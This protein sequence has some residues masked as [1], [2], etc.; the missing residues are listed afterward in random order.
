MEAG[1]GEEVR[2]LF[3]GCAVATSVCCALA[4]ET[5][6]LKDDFETADAVAKWTL[7]K[8]VSLVDGAGVDG[9][10]GL[11]WEQNEFREMQMVT[12]TVVTVDG[13]AVRPMP[14]AVPERFV[15][16]VSV[17][18]GRVYSISAKVRGA[19]TNNCLYLFFAWYDKDGRFIGRA[20]G[21]PTIYRQ[22]GCKGWEVVRTK[23]QRLP[24]DAASAKLFVELYRTTL[25]RMAF[26]DFTV[27]C[28]EARH[29][30]RVF[31][32]AYRN[33]QESGPV[34]FVAPY[35]ASPERFPRAR[36][37][38]EFSFVGADGDFTLKTDTVTD[39]RFEVTVDCARLK[40]GMSSVTARLF[41]DGKEL[42]S[43]AMDFTRAKVSRKV[44]FDA[45]QRLIVDGKPFLPLGVFVHPR[46]KEVAYL[47][48]LRNS[49]FN[50]VI[51]CTPEK[52]IM[53]K[54]HAAGLMTLPKMTWNLKYAAGMAR[55]LRDHPSLLAW[56]VIDEVAPDRADEKR[57]LQ[58][59]VAENDPDHPTF[60]VLDR[61]R[62]A[63]AM[64]GAFDIVSCDPYPVGR[65]RGELSKASEF[66]TLCRRKTYGLCPLWQ[67]PQ[68]FAWDWCHKYGHP[69]EDRYPTYE[70]LRSM[71]WQAIAAGANGLL[72]Y[73][74]HHI[75]KCSPAERLEENW[76]N[77]VKVADEIKSHGDVIL[78][79]GTTATSS[80]PS[81]VVRAFEKDGAVWLLAA[82][83]ERVEST[84]VVDVPG[85]RR[86]KVTLPALGVQLKK[87]GNR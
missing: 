61:P 30:E 40:E 70:E 38:G 41:F 27:T 22:V 17:E 29:L 66:P 51:E 52:A 12:Q 13:N 15:R 65:N 78:S 4:V 68:S 37:S 43:A 28:D 20:E 2:K 73:S 45:A 57:E 3:V 79:E 35:V 58:K 36:L 64:M 75:F 50:C 87:I 25:G 67:V 84:A 42:A 71:A 39:D 63:D 80:S 53:D 82:N 34:R 77:L 56:Y 46:D 32:S 7:C 31:S 11:V 72:W 86:G 8:G 26:D 19:I 62:N 81:V 76:G 6:V 5:V 18:P 44:T 74:A 14:T 85:V 16:E 54:F 60:A 10:R 9:S 24:S 48:R 55:E 47:D 23:T 21:Q 59:I 49:P 33:T 83:A 1:R 69:D